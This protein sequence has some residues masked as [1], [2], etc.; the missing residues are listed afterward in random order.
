MMQGYVHTKLA[1]LA[2]LEFSKYAADYDLEKTAKSVQLQKLIE[3]KKFSDKNKYN[4]KNTILTELL[5]KYPREFKIDSLLNNN[6]V[7]LTH[8]PSG[9]KIHAPR[10]LIPVGIE[11]ANKP[12][13]S[14][15]KSV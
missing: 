2:M 8:K 7:G 5:K 13:D 11:I 1:A 3:A 10:T 4:E 14:V 6:Y 12:D 15:K 9:F